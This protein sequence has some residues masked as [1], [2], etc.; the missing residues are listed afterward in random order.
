MSSS[1]ASAIYAIPVLI[2]AIALYLHSLVSWKLRSRGRPLPP[3]PK[4]LPLIGNL[5]DMPKVRPWIGFL[6]L[7]AEY[8][9]VLCMQVLNKTIIVLGDPSA[10]FEFM[11]RRSANTSDRKMTQ[12]V[13]LT[14]Q[15]WNW[16]FFEYGSQWRHHRRVFW[17]HFH[18]G[19]ISKYRSAQRAGAHA[20]LVKL[21]KHAGSLEECIN[22]SFTSAVLKIAYG[23]DITD[24][25]DETLTIVREGVEGTR[26][27][28][29]S[30]GFAVDHLPFLRHLPSFFPGAGFKKRFAE[31]RKATLRL[32]DAPFER[33]Q[34]G[35]AQHG[36]PDCVVTDILEN[37][38]SED[39]E[40]EKNQAFNP[41]TWNPREVA[42]SVGGNIF[43]AG[44]DTT[45]STMETFFLAMSLY[46]EV[47]KKA[48]AE[49]D[50]VVGP[51]R[52]PDFNDREELVYVNAI[53]KEASRWLNVAPLGMSHTTL[54]D[55]E[56]QGYFIPAGT[57]LMANVWACLHDPEAYED[58]DVFRPERFIRDGR[59]D[60]DVRDP[61]AF[62]FG[63]GRRICPGRYFADAALFINIASVLHVF[64]ITPPLDEKGREIRIEP[65]MTDSFASAPEDCRCTITP[66]G[67][68]AEAL[69]L[70]AEQDLT[71]GEA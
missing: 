35:L 43:E 7:C 39:E 47:Q 69:I 59:L 11:D 17:Q 32:R 19:A 9:N 29:V 25:K 55:D 27:V 50:A 41:R 68:W 5:L 2:L 16:A 48:Q 1:S 18:P 24:A 31:W 38:Y 64:N 4:G 57:I 36:A 66:R 54:E 26:E 20:L 67:P 12:S 65:R 6:D 42:M 63:F 53:I 23:I 49:L 52:L 62:A 46:P 21:S 61:Y 58:P 45:L 37:A 56:F 34:E 71:L 40:D 14:G 22:Y 28:L 60:P 13:I 8:G 44:S 30:G 15:A 3:G 70:S 33:Y 10:I 51:D